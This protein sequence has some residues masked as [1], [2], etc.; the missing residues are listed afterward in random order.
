M[1]QA[2]DISLFAPPRRRPKKSSNKRP[3]PVADTP[4]TQP[5]DEPARASGQPLLPIAT[6]SRQHSS[7]TGSRQAD[8]E[9]AE[10]GQEA[11]ER[12]MAKADGLSDSATSFR[13]L[14]VSDWLDRVCR[15]LGMTTPTQVRCA[16]LEPGL[17][18]FLPTMYPLAT[19]AKVFC[20][21]AQPCL[22]AA[23]SRGAVE[24]DDDAPL[25]CTGA[26][27]LHPGRAGRQ[28][29]HRHSAHRQRQDGGFCAAHPPAPVQGPLR[30]LCA[31]AHADKVQTA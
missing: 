7:D 23:K 31:G 14:G 1:E 4:A 9:P 10:H 24:T 21:G 17:A 28:G 22:T 30:R 15:S 19:K 6:G 8:A 26:A 13:D 25:M 2:S 29:R 5:S 3:A 11:A 16:C 27:G 18:C 12:G 20:F